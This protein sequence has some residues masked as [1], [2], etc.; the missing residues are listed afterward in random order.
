MNEILCR[1]LALDCSCLEQ[2]VADG[3]N[4]FTVQRYQEGRRLL[5]EE[6]ECYLK[7]IVVNGKLLF[8]GAESIL[9]W[10]EKQYG[11]TG[12]E[13]FFEFRRLQKLEEKLAETG[14]QI[15][16]V[17]PYYIPDRL[18]KMDARGFELRWYEG[19]EIE[20]F[21]GDRR[22]ERAYSFEADAPDVIGVAAVRE[23]RIIGMAGASCDSPTMWQIGIDVDQSARR[24]GV[25]QVLV[26]ELARAI[27]R[28]GILPFYGTAMSHIGSQK[29]ALRAGFLPA[30]A[31]LT[32]KLA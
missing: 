4:H 27:E 19:V 17:R 3:R 26:S 1:Q 24:S 20:Q 7:V 14:H 6:K 5:W 2:D 21:R 16:L 15:K 31:E 28:K 29:V 22:F 9:R 23:N 32:T 10:C 13:W 30:W 11:E 25:A 8:T 12:G 18:V